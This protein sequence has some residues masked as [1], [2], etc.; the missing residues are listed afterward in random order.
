MGEECSKYNLMEKVRKERK[1][2]KLCRSHI[3]TALL[4]SNSFCQFPSLPFHFTQPNSFGFL[5]RNKRILLHHT[6]IF[7]QFTGIRSQTLYQGIN[8]FQLACKLS[9][10]SNLKPHLHMS[11]AIDSHVSTINENTSVNFN[12]LPRSKDSLVTTTRLGQKKTEEIG[13][14]EMNLNTK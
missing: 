6:N 1:I 2:S 3:F 10:W 11:I 12:I 5:S 8:I 9:M 13:T 14:Q 7:L 4:N